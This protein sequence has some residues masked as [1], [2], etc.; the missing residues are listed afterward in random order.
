MAINFAEKY[1]NAVDEAFSLLSVTDRAVNN[2]FDFTGAKT[3]KVYDMPTAPMGDYTTSG[4]NRYGTPS[5]LQD[6]VQELTLSR[7]RSFTFTL[8]KINSVDTPE[9]VRDAGK[10]LARQLSQVVIPEIDI[11]RLAAMG[12]G[13]GANKT[14]TITKDNAYETFLDAQNALREAKAPIPNRIAYVSPNFYK[15]IKLDDAFIKASDLAQ[16]TLFNGQVGAIDGVAIIPVPTS[17]MPENAEF[18]LTHA[19]A[20]TSPIKL[21]EYKIHIDPPGIA[22]ALV[23]GLVYYDAFVLKNKKG[24]IYLHTSA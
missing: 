5:E 1:S 16:T 11:Y 13:A 6:D 19:V 12:A 10:A 8:D 2:D 17:Y 15:C 21:A 14:L 18:L 7:I 3:V 24:A 20:T 4:A 9:G 22:G 23:E